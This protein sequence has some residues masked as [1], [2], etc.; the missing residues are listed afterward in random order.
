MPTAIELILWSIFLM[1]LLKAYVLPFL[2]LIT[3][4]DFIWIPDWIAS[5]GGYLIAIYMGFIPLFGV[6]DFWLRN[7]KLEKRKPKLF[8]LIFM[9]LML[10]GGLFAP[11]ERIFIRGDFPLDVFRFLSDTPSSGLAFA[12]LIPFFKL[13]KEKRLLFFLL[14]FSTQQFLLVRQ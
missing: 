6:L 14:P 2:A 10:F 8:H 7:G 11:L 12:F 3:K 5:P 9:I 4:T 1:G 13:E